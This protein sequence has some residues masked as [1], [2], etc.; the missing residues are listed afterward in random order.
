MRQSLVQAAEPLALHVEL[1]DSATLA[2]AR[3]DA[4][5]LPAMAIGELDEIAASYDGAR[6]LSGSLVWSDAE[7]GWIADWR[8]DGTDE[9]Y[10]WQVRGVS[11]DEAFRNAMAGSLQVLSGNGQP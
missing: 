2:A 10:T 6:A 11:F 4:I 7:L 5:T 9:T 3:L 8:L 1:P